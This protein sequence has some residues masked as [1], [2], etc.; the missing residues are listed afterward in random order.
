MDAVHPGMVPMY[1][2][3]FDAKNEYEMIQNCK[4]LQD[5]F[6]KL[7]ITKQIEVNKLIKGRPL[8]NLE[9]MQWMK[10]YCRSVNGGNMNKK[11][12]LWIICQNCLVNRHHFGT[13]TLRREGKRAKEAKK[14][15]RKQQPLN[16]RPNLPLLP[17]KLN[18]RP[19]ELISVAYLL[20][21][22]RLSLLH[23]G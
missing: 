15:A 14:Q 3:N 7:N 11:K 1:K 16:H 4:V 8:Y 5:V 19:V 23:E 21:G 10:S 12:A 9:F 13:S 18:L 6:N 2:V 17:Q 22:G 20:H